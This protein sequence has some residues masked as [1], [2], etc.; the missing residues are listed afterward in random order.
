[1][2]YKSLHDYKTFKEQRTKQKEQSW[3]LLRNST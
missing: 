2:F 1:M 3:L